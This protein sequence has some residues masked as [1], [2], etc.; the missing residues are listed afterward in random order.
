M[1]FKPTIILAASLAAVTQVNAH[2]GLIIPPCRNNH[3]NVN[4]F[5]F[6]KQPGERWLTGGGCAGDMCLWFNDGCFIGCP[7]CTSIVAVVPGTSGE[8]PDRFIKPNCEKPI[9]MEPTLPEE[10]RTWNIGNPSTYGDWTKYHPWRAPGYAPV[11]DPC[12]RAGANTEQSGGGETPIGAKQFDRGS[13]LPK[14]DVVTTWQSG[15][16][17]EVG[18]MVGSNHGGGYVY[19]LCPANETLT[20]ECFQKTTLPFVGD[21]HKIRRL[22]NTSLPDPE[23]TM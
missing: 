16:P 8:V 19:S 6:T 18:W 15:Q 1:N 2:G 3:G 14:L 5:N 4:I 21:W 17:A 12:G 20:E 13:L 10:F 11:S 23:Y 7:N 22:D 9:L